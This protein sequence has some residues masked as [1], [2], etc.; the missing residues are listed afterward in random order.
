MTPAATAS[1]H[2]LTFLARHAPLLLFALVILIFSILSPSFRT[3]DNARNILVQ[4]SSV[5]ILAVGMTFVLLTGGI[6]LSVGAFMFLS[7]AIAGKLVQ[8][9]WIPNIP[10]L[11]VILTLPTLLLLG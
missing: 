4:C 9:N 5:A 8:G 11:P 2:K 10:P 1:P 6:D 7:A 3:L